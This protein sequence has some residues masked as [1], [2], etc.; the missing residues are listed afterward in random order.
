MTDALNNTFLNSLCSNSNIIG[1]KYKKSETGF[2]ITMND[3]SSDN[4]LS[5]KYLKFGL[6]NIQI[7]VILALI[8]Y[9]QY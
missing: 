9:F 8:T 7:Y 4:I 3:K 6:Y 2:S 5:N 1:C